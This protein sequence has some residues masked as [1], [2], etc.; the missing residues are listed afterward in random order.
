MRN[1]M[2]RRKVLRMRQR[3]PNSV[4]LA[5]VP[6]RAVLIVLD[7][8][9]LVCSVGAELVDLA[10]V[11]DEGFEFTTEGVALDPV[12]PGPP[13]STTPLHRLNH[14]VTSRR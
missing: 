5:I 14:S 11:R 3:I 12:H 4:V 8:E 9:E 2:R 10:V 13:V 7:E 6:E 1:K